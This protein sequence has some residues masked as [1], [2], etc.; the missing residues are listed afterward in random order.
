MATK[1]KIQV[2]QAFTEGKVIQVASRDLDNWSDLPSCE[3]PLWDWDH[4]KYRVKPINKM[5]RPYANSEEFLKAQKEHGPYLMSCGQYF[6]PVMIDCDKGVVFTDVIKN[7]FR[8]YFEIMRDK[9]WQ[10]GSPCG[11]TEE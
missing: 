6:F 4:C 1:D 5:P 3:E 9:V 11:I 7:G 2:M 8:S 10:D